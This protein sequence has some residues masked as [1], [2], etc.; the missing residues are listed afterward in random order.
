MAIRSRLS[1][2]LNR[3]LGKFGYALVNV[4][5]GRGKTVFADHHGSRY[6]YESVMILDAYA[7]WAVDDDFL[8]VWD[9]VNTHTLTDIWRCYELY[10]LV[11]E[12]SDIPGDILEV[13]VW[14]G[15]TGATLAAAAKKWKPDARVWL[16]DTFTGVVKAGDNDASYSGGEHAD[17]SA[18][19]VRRLLGSLDLDNVDILPGIFPEETGGTLESN[20]ISLCHI[21]V[22]VYQSASDIVSWVLPKMA[23][24]AV[25]VFDDYGFSS[26]N[27]ITRLVDDLRADGNWRYLYNLNK[28]AILTRR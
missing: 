15:G 18:D 13:G 6:A 23:R 20:V 16:C 11:R 27:G 7:P 26:C 22:D 17:T 25:L 4:G 1:S 5:G 14:R 3:G 9:K 12:V 24:D 8:E 10:Q 2:T 19:A 28:H 21:D